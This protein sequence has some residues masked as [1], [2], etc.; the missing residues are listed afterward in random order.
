MTE[1]ATFSFESLQVRTVDADG[2]VWFVAAD[3]CDALGLDDTSKTCSRLDDDERG[4][5][6]VRT[7]SGDQQML[8]ISESGLYSLILTS[9]KAEARKFKRWVTSEV[10]PSIRKTGS[11]TVQKELA[12]AQQLL[13]TTQEQLKLSHREANRWQDKVIYLEAEQLQR[14]STIED[15]KATKVTDLRQQ[16][17]GVELKATNLNKTIQQLLQQVSTLENALKDQKELTEDAQHEARTA[18]IRLR[19]AR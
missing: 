14:A 11:Y 15:A 19:A 4:T 18:Q 8:V 13:T 7:P 1:I 6:T 3:V 16:V 10:L 2:A 17:K 12:T 5:N 9:R